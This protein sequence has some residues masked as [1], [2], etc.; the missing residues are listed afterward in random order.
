[1]HLPRGALF[2][3]ALSVASLGLDA[4]AQCAQPVVTPDADRAARDHFTRGRDAFSQGDFATAAREFS[5]AHELS[6]RHQLLYNIGASYERLH[7]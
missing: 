4:A 2:S 1:M 3:F 5:Q 7:N 6:G